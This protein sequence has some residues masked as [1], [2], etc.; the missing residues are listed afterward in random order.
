MSYFEMKLFKANGRVFQPVPKRNFGIE[1]LEKNLEDWLGENPQLLGNEILLIGRQVK[2]DH[3]IIDL[4]ALDPKGNAVVIELKRGRATREVVGQLNSYLTIVNR[5]SDRDL[6]K[7]ANL[8]PYNK[9][10]SNLI[11]KFKEHFKCGQAPDFNA[12]QIG[13]V[14]AEDYDPDF[15]AQIGGLRF[16][17]RVLQFSNF[18]TPSNDEYLLITPLHDSTEDEE[19]SAPDSNAD[20]EIPASKVSTELRAKFS[21]RLDTVY[22][23]L[24]DDVCRESDGWRLH[25]SERYVQGVLSRWHTVWEGISLYFDHETGRNYLHTNSVPK[26]NRILSALLKAQKPALQQALGKDIIWDGDKHE[27]IAEWVSDEPAQIAERIKAY[28]KNLQ[29][30][31]D[32]ALPGRSLTAGS[33]GISKVQLD[34]W[35]GFSKY[36][37]E[38][39][40]KLRLPSPRPKGFIMIGIEGFLLVAIATQNRI[41]VYVAIKEP[42]RKKNFELFKKDKDSLEKE[43][44]E[45]LTWDPMPHRKE[46]QIQTHW[47][48]KLLDRSTWPTTYEWM[49]RSLERFHAA[50][51]PRIKVL[52]KKVSSK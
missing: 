17:C 24:K 11:K 45:P 34:F 9:E 2:T 18:V 48:G 22:A 41:T 44:G 6:E 28:I 42:N 51:A 26:H 29:P 21:E 20:N 3:G 14:V 7:N 1:R 37:T 33:E 52:K 12:D 5:W 8:I 27:S 30:Y 43:I 40:S 19:K 10:S 4:L 39:G 38:S 16:E 25:K 46:S 32:Q 15:V 13:V 47:Q 36:A 35:T 23:L 50:F 49:L 31:L